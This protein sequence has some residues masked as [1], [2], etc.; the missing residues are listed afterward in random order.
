MPGRVLL[1]SGV[2]Q[3]L[4]ASQGA[5]GTWYCMAITADEPELY[6]SG[7]TYEQVAFWETCLESA[8]AGGW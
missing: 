1:T 6:G 3:A 7:P 4:L 8:S 5:T 2:D